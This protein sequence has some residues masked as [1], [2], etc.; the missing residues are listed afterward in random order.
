MLLN[1]DGSFTRDIDIDELTISFGHHYG[2]TICLIKNKITYQ[3][4]IHPTIGYMSFPLD[5]FVKNEMEIS[6]GQFNE[7]S[8]LIYDAGLLDLFDEPLDDTMYPGAVYRSLYCTFDDGASY[9]YRTH[10]SPK[11]AF[12]Q[13]VGILSSFCK[14]ET[15][16]SQID[17]END[18]KERIVFVT[19]CCD[20]VALDLWKY[21]PKCGKA[22]EIQKNKGVN[23]SFDFD[24]TMWLCKS[25]GEGIP[26][27][28][29]Y[30]GRCGNKRDW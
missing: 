15:V 17:F 5:Y 8:N 23:D 29:K 10:G 16:E 12:N 9:Q 6:K 19:E 1:K 27:E 2:K 21:C 30:C 24:Q 7:L 22:T 14:L 11:K 13:I 20:A 26:M 3:N 28:Y 18:K 25:C 4:T